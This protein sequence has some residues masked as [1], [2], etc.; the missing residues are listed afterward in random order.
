[1]LIILGSLILFFVAAEGFMV[2]YGRHRVNTKISHRKAKDL[3][4]R[5]DINFDINDSNTPTCSCLGDW[6]L[7]IHYLL[8]IKDSCFHKTR[9]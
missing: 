7:V 6:I 3:T 9:G 2:S 4:V 8:I 5:F 1:M